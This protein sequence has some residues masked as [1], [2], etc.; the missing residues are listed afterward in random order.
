MAEGLQGRDACLTTTRT[1]IV[2][3]TSRGTG[4]VRNLHLLHVMAQRV[5]MR[6]CIRSSTTNAGMRC[7]TACSAARRSHGLAVCVAEN[8]DRL[9]F[10]FS[11]NG[12][13]IA[14]NAGNGTGRLVA[15]SLT[16]GM[17]D[18]SRLA[19]LYDLIG[20]ATRAIHAGVTGGGTRRIDDLLYTEIVTESAQRS[21][22]CL[23][24]TKTR[25]VHLTSR[26]TGG[27]SYLYLL[28]IVTRRIGISIN[29]RTLATSTCMRGPA[30]RGAARRCHCGGVTMAE[31]RNILRCIRIPAI[32]TR[33]LRCSLSCTRGRYTYRGAI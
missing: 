15:V 3:L 21:D 25:I 16:P 2:H 4:G 33:I 30:S 8:L 11:A 1:R 12:T 13:L 9:C 19:S 10:A 18:H 31:S 26:G 29:I 5:R 17:R 14:L 7:P 6:V 28:H 22:A 23:T 32:G 20:I 27:V 24:T